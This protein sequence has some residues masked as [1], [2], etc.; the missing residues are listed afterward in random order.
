MRASAV[1]RSVMSH[2]V[3]LTD[4]VAQAVEDAHC[5]MK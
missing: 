4:A 2:P 5:V 1:L 3:P